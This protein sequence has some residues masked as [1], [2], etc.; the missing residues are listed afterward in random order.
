MWTVY[1][2][3][4]SDDAPAQRELPH[5]PDGAGA[6][7]SDEVILEGNM[8]W[9]CRLRWLAIAGLAVLALV[10]WVSSAALVTTGLRLDP[11]GLSAAA[12]ILLLLNLAWLL[13]ARM[14]SHSARRAAV[15]RRT[16]W[17]QILL[18][19][20][21]L[22]AVVHFLG[23]VHT[24]APFMYL[25]HIVLACIFLPY[26]RSLAVAL[27]G[28]GMY[29]ACLIMESTGAIGTGSVPAGIAVGSAMPHG[30]AIPMTVLAVQFFSVGFVSLTVWYLASR[31]SNDLRRRDE[32]L[33]AIN[34][35]LQAA[36]EERAS[37]MLQT[38]HQLKA[39]F[40]AIH[41]NAQI[42]LGGHCGPLPPAAV[43]VV[44]QIAARCE[45]LSRGITA[46]LQLSNLRSQAQNPPS[47]VPL[48]LSDTVRSCLAAMKP[49]AEKRGILFEENLSPANVL[50]VQDHAVMI[51]DN[52]LS[53]AVNYS[54]DGQRIWVSARAK[55]DGGAI[56]MVRDCGIGIPADKLPRIFDDYYRTIE[57]ARH[58][59]GSTGLG[60]AIVRQTAIAG[61]IGVRVESAPASGTV[62]TLDFPSQGG[63]GAHGV[64]V[65]RG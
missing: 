24:F 56:I 35:R 62:F 57:A 13:L 32:E 6:E 10:G 46:M 25:F 49:Q 42:L 55:P 44:E 2:L 30:G 27:A 1:E 50:A 61:G 11:V 16:L 45:A 14:G 47:P 31:L 20:A 37:H 12:G 23:S 18:D 60:L 48:D 4:L 3:P 54:T 51:I 58:N 41:A 64:P 34:G 38:T 28:M 52:I 8:A 59:R 22:T 43:V 15:A 7:K 63:R 36:T 33:L 53:N 29:L 40:A 19:L 26:A 17:L 39:P 21:V 65:D 9:F 5:G